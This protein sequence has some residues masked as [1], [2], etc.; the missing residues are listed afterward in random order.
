M[1]AKV[2]H[3]SDVD[4]IKRR[5]EKARMARQAAID[6]LQQ[7][8]EEKRMKNKEVAEQEI[9]RNFIRCLFIKLSP[10]QEVAK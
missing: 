1:Q 9:V 3:D 6:E 4:K 8:R 5:E 2:Q 10:Q 7:K